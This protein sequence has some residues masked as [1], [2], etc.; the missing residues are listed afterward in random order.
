MESSSSSDLVRAQLFMS[1]VTHPREKNFE[2]GNFL[3]R[4]KERFAM[5]KCPIRCPITETA[6]NYDV[7]SYV[8][9]NCTNLRDFYVIKRALVYVI[10]VSARWETYNETF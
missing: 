1:A 2:C 6:K 10:F 3:A 7:Y 5:H 8:Y 9:I 4:E